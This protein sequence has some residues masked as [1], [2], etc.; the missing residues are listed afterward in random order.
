MFRVQAVPDKPGSF[1]NRIGLHPDWRGL[2][3]KE[4]KEKSGIH[5]IEF[6]HNS[7]FI[8]GAWSLESV[9]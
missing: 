2:R 4:L 8:G 7:G 3:E 5:D 9:I 1:L 6:V